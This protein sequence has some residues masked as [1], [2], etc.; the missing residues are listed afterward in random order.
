MYLLC[1][2][3]LRGDP[4]LS[5]FGLSSHE[6]RNPLNG[7]VGWLRVLQDEQLRNDHYELLSN[8]FE[9]TEAALCY[10]GSMSMMYKLEGKKIK[11][12]ITP[13]KLSDVVGRVERIIRPQVPET[14]NFRVCMDE[15]MRSAPRL[16]MDG[17]LLMQVLVN[18]CQNAARFTTTGS[19]SIVVSLANGNQA[20]QNDHRVK[21]RT[22]KCF[23][24]GRFT[25][26]GGR[27]IGL[28]PRRLRRTSSGVICL[29]S[30]KKSSSL[31]TFSKL[32][33]PRQLATNVECTN[34]EASYQDTMLVNF[35]VRD[36]GCGIPPP[37]LNKIFSRYVSEGGVGIGLYLSKMLIESLG[38]SMDFSSPWDPNSTGTSFDF[39]LALPTYYELS[40][41]SSNKDTV[42][43]SPP[44]IIHPEKEPHGDDLQ[45]D[46]GL[47][48]LS[49]IMKAA[50]VLVADDLLMNRKLLGRVF[51]TNFGSIVT[52]ASSAEEVTQRPLF[53]ES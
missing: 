29:S 21:G 51:T 31:S 18:L 36:T 19:I 49:S 2:E 3:S 52:E 11:P 28:V 14:V 43:P 41:D 1:S 53:L 7:T 35:A 23:S 37:A 48:A 38:S 8:A 22:K 24:L 15:A 5:L 10:L 39:T 32:A 12:N 45:K 26:F 16:M 27:R 42:T 13:T 46:S 20:Q 30:C 4:L 33:T 17:S 6:V 47:D 50:H 25:A 40:E 44:E 9:C 34:S